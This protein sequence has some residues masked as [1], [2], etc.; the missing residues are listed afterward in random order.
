MPTA[1]QYFRIVGKQFAAIPDADV[2]VWLDMA[3]TLGAAGCLMGDPANLAA[4]LYAAHLM[5]LDAENMTGEGGRGPIKSEKEGDLARTYGSVGGSAS[6]WLS[7][8][9]YGLQYD[10]MLVGCVGSGIMTRYG[11]DIPQGVELFNGL[12]PYY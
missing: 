12:P 5:Y 1:L 7:L 3:G 8:S 10:Q 11:S 2:Q 9:P 4:A 6:G